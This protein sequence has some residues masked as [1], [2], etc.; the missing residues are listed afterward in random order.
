M[1]NAA[2]HKVPIGFVV[3]AGMQKSGSTL[4]HEYCKALV[5]RQHGDAG[6]RAFADWIQTGPVGGSGSFPFYYP[7]V[8]CFLSKKFMPPVS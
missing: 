3:S 1:D 5:C 7:A 6:Q 8:P 2:G 4:L